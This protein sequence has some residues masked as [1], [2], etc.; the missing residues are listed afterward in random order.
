MHRGCLG[1]LA[2]FNGTPSDQ[3]RLVLTL[4][5]A[6]SS[7]QQLLLHTSAVTEDNNNT[8]YLVV[9]SSTQCITELYCLDYFSDEDEDDYGRPLSPASPLNNHPQFPNMVIPELRLA[10]PIVTASKTKLVIQVI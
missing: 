8:G 5:E 9:S 1:K 10:K 6:D 2:S 3:D 7:L 4:L